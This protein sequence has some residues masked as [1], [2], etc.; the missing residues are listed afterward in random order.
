M[1]CQPCCVPQRLELVARAGTANGIEWVEV[2]DVGAPPGVPRQ[3]TLFVRLLLPAPGL[4]EANVVIDGGSRIAEVGI[5]WAGMGDALPAAAEPSV[6]ALVTEPT[7]TLVIRTD[8][9]GDFSRYRLRI[10]AGIANASAPVGFDPVLADTEFSFK[11]GCP[12]EFDCADAQPCPPAPR[13]KPDIDYLVKDYPGFRR[14]MLD[15]LSLL[16]PGWTERSAADV[17]VT[18]VEL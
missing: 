6:A 13:S 10:V 17:G 2:L 7:R 1:T 3:Q 15:R 4:T 14:L 5:V 12:S 9:N 18:L 16:A 11:V 8:S